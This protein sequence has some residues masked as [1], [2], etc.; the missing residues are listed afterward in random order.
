[1]RPFV[2]SVSLSFFCLYYKNSI[3]EIERSVPATD[4]NCSLGI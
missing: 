4:G 2:F 3:Y 1:M